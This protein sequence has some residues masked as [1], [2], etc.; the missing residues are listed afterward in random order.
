MWPDPRRLRALPRTRPS[1]DAKREPC[2]SRLV[3]PRAQSRLRVEPA[4][5]PRSRARCAA[6]PCASV[7]SDDEQVR[8]LLVDRADDARNDAA[9]D[10]E[11]L[12]LCVDASQR[13]A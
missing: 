12:A 5:P 8:L 1:N 13:L 9:V 2:L 7:G 10:D 4:A 3:A 6:D 11:G